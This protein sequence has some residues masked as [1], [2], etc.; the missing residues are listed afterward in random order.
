MAVSAGELIPDATFP[1]KA[2][3]AL[4][5]FGIAMLLSYLGIWAIKLNFLLFFKRLGTKEI[6]SYAIFWWVVLIFTIACGAISIGLMQ[7]HC[8]MG[9]IDDI[10]IKCPQRSVLK[11]TYDFF[12]VSCILDVL[13]DASS[14]CIPGPALY[15]PLT[16]PVLCFPLYILWKISITLKKKLILSTIFGFVAFTMAITIIR[17]SIFGGIYKTIEDDKRRDLNVSWIWFWF[18]IEFSV[19]KFPISTTHLA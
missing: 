8:M 9:P 19:C 6:R 16:Y 13:S 18:F 11:Q 12:K 5:G 10:M 14:K 17:G 7:F 1:V 15:T 2:Q 4:R 3:A